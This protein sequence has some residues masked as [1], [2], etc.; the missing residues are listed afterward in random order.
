GGRERAGGGE[1]GAGGG[2]GGGGGRVGGAVGAGRAGGRRGGGVRGGGGGEHLLVAGL[3]DRARR[4][5]HGVPGRYASF[6]LRQPFPRR[7][8][9]RIG[10]R[11]PAIRSA[12][13]CRM[14]GTVTRLRHTALGFAP[15]LPGPAPAAAGGTAVARSTN[16]G[17]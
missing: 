9:E 14:I 4:C 8:R 15:E 2:G 13:C 16:K 1:E 5:R 7:H 17:G 6:A 3:D 10:R 11:G 12:R